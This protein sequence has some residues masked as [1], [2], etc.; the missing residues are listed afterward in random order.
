VIRVT[1]PA[2]FVVVK[3][4]GDVWRRLDMSGVAVGGPELRETRMARCSAEDGCRDP[5]A[6]VS[7]C[8]LPRRTFSGWF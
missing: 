8:E 6:T 7:L 4:H 3:F 5:G 2:E 1:L